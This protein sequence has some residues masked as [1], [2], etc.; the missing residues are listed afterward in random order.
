MRPFVTRALETLYKLSSSEM[1]QES[2]HMPNRQP[3]AMNH[4]PRVSHF[5]MPFCFS[6]VCL[7]ILPSNPIV[8]VSLSLLLN[9]VN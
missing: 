6:M 4:G 9:V 5:F 1:I 2:D 8:H 7:P 3:Q